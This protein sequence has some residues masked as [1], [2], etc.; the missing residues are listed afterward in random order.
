MNTK[1]PMIKAS[2]DAERELFILFAKT[3]NGFAREQVV[4]AAINLIVNALRQTHAGQKAALDEF[5]MLTAK[6]RALLAEHYDNMGKR[7]N[8]FP[9]HQTIE[10]PMFD[11]R[12]D[13][14]VN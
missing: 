11:A 8:I 13:R 14:K 5:D 1:D 3:A 9:F 10:M 12:P 4:G 2:P 7:R 6:T